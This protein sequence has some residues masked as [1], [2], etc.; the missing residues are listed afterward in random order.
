[1][2]A[3][4]SRFPRKMYGSSKFRAFCF[5]VFAKRLLTN[6]QTDTQHQTDGGEIKTTNIRIRNCELNP[7]IHKVFPSAYS[8]HEVVG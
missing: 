6:K 2:F 8:S 4:F 1:M 3:H 7:I 5:V